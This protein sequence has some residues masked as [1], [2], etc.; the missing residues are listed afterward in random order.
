MMRLALLDDYQGIALRMAD[1][2]RLAG[3]MEVVAFPRNIPD[4]ESLAEALKDF[5]AVMLMRE[6]TKFP[7]ALIE[8][9]PK[10][11]LLITAA[12][13]NASVDMDAAAEHGVQ[14]CGTNDL[15]HAAA[16]L[17][18]GMMLSLARHIPAEDHAMRDGRWQITVGTS[19]HGKTLGIVGLGILGAQMA[20]YAR[21][22]GMRAIAWSQ[23]L[24]TEVA[25]AAGATR[26]EKEQLFA[27]SD[28]VSVHLKLSPRTRGVIGAADLARMKPTAYLINTARGPIIDEASLLSVLKQRRIAG[29]ALDVYD[30][31]PL[32]VDHPFRSLDNVVILP[33]LGYV[34]EENYQLIYADTLDD[35]EAFLAG[36]PLRPLNE[37]VKRE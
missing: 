35:V 32:P 29:A 2:Q 6:R 23:N 20:S 10:L 16:E 25:A 21:V 5:D 26:V 3:R 24:T 7:R 34:T 27:E 19:L 13:W 18:L 14:V 17:A 12:L 11:K 33:H 9:L 36:K 4:V 37:P 31:E 22:L 1:W 15:S 30:Q 28:V 8:R